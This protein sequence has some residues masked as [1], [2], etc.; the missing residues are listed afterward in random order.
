MKSVAV[1]L[2][3]LLAGCLAPEFDASDLSEGAPRPS[4]S[5]TPSP[6]AG[7]SYGLATEGVAADLPRQTVDLGLLEALGGQLIQ[8]AVEAGCPVAAPEDPG[9]ALVVLEERL[10]ACATPERPLVDQRL[11]Q[12]KVEGRLAEAYQDWR[13]VAQVEARVL[14]DLLNATVAG[15]IP[16][17]EALAWL[18]REAHGVAFR[19]FLEEPR[20]VEW[21]LA[22][23]EDEQRRIA[24]GY[25]LDPAY[26]RLLQAVAHALPTEGAC[27]SPPGAMDDATA[28]VQR[29]QNLSA[30]LAGPYGLGAGFTWED[31]EEQPGFL[32]MAELMGEE[33]PAAVAGAKAGWRIGFWHAVDD[34]SVPERQEA[35]ALI[36]AYW[37]AVPGFWSRQVLAGAYDGVTGSD[38]PFD[39][40]WPEGVGAPPEVLVELAALPT[41]LP[42][43]A[44]WTCLA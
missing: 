30:R 40:W 10:R 36:E 4:G 41:L 24:Y 15:S 17:L 21:F 8:A 37:D 35:Q 29:A 7:W 18:W 34:G 20:D 14:T 9:H 3:V 19:A 44:D 1:L 26:A 11:T 38:R 32:E 28:N 27:T 5:S 23:A 42:P 31:R 13:G 2:V 6:L 33:V 39:R 16:E 25:T 12:A 22:Q 43:F